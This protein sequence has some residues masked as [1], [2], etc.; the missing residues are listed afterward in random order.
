MTVEQLAAR[1]QSIKRLQPPPPAFMSSIVFHYSGDTRE[2]YTDIARWCRANGGKEDF[3]VRAGE[4]ASYENPT[5]G[6]FADAAWHYS[7][8]HGSVAFSSGACVRPDGTMSAAILRFNNSELALYA[9]A[10]LSAF[11]EKYVEVRKAREKADEER[12]EKRREEDKAAFD[13]AVLALDASKDPSLAEVPSARDSIDF[14]REKL[15]QGVG[16][17]RLSDFGKPMSSTEP[18]TNPCQFTSQSERQNPTVLELRELDLNV[19]DTVTALTRDRILGHS[20]GEKVPV[21]QLKLATKSGVGFAEFDDA[22]T[23]KRCAKAFVAVARRC[24]AK[25]DTR[26][27]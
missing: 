20:N 10:E 14:L 1:W 7:A 19:V 6:C 26:F 17:T 13:R 24:G 22:D 25:P 12:A 11:V 9:G 8:T 23:A 18:A 2:A 3:H 5:P 16:R 4:C 27:K 21:F 15:R